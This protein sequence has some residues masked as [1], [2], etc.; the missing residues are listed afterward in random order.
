MNVYKTRVR[1]ALLGAAA[2]VACAV[3]TGCVTPAPQMGDD[4]VEPEIVL[5]MW[6][7]TGIDA[8]PDAGLQ[9]RVEVDEATGCVVATGEADDESRVTG[10]IFPMG[11]E[12][13]GDG[14]AVVLLDGSR[15]VF[16]EEVLLGGGGSE[17]ESQALEHRGRCVFDDYFLVNPPDRA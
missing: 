15:L 11:T 12:V 9:A 7:V 17:E 2:S 5:L 13:A 16:G 8:F 3:L 6:D 4:E 1:G 14:A 10:L